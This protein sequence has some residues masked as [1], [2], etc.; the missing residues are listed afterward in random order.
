MKDITIIGL[1]VMG[2]AL[3]RTLLN[4]DYDVTIWNRSPEKSEVLRG[5]GV[6]ISATCSDAVAASST[7][8]ICIK[9]HTD[10]RAILESAQSLA[11]KNII[12]LSTGSAPD[13]ESLYQWVNEQG[14]NC[15]IGMICTFPRGIGEQDSTIVTVGS[16][17]LW[18]NSKSMLKILAGKSSYIGEQVGSLAILYSAL[19]L[20]RQGFMFGMIYGALLCKKAGV[21]MDTYV[22]QMPLTIKVVHDYY[23]VFASSVPND[24]Y[25]NPQAS[26]DTYVAAFADTLESFKDN[27]VNDELPRL[28][29]KLVNMGADA[30]MG[31]NQITSLINLLN[32]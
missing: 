19:F 13:A 8:V 11:N 20:P 27:G 3:A 22:E 12:E 4:N 24:D 10:S 5:E 1:G 21:S 16:K 6:K 31:E 29:A 15:L 17:S 25:S 30:G 28:M 14:A 26:I 2:T 7:V 18:N 23:D 9:S 32:E